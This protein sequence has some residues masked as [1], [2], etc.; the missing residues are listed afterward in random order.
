MQNSN[1]HIIKTSGLG[2]RFP[3]G[4]GYIQA[5]EKLDLNIR[6][7]E[8]FSIVGPSG[9]GKTTLLRCLAGIDK[10]DAGSFETVSQEGGSIPRLAM[11]FQEHG[12]YPWMTVKKNLL[13]VL[14]ASPLDPGEHN[15]IISDL[16]SKVGLSKYDQFYPNQL[17]GGMAQRVALVRAFCVRPKIL[18][19]D[20]PFVF[21]DYQTRITLQ[22]LLLDL[23]REA[24]QTVIFVT[25]NINEAAALSDRVAVMSRR[26][27]RIRRKIECD[28]PR[29]R[30]V[31]EL[32]KNRDFQDIV[33][34]I[35]RLLSQ[36]DG[37]QVD[38]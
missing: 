24:K 15:R 18:L 7:G 23:W 21:L 16:L 8:F 14:R 13:F 35:T 5:F 29:P 30:D 37:E 6:N 28:F 17:S 2:K 25:H 12:L 11:V 9:C 10:P 31:I 38:V 33:V 4:D 19:M 32:R 3:K 34:R 1:R 26:P 20:E 36:G 27:G 22:N